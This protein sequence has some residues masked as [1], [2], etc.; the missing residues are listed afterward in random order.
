MSTRSERSSISFLSM[1]ERKSLLFTSFSASRSSENDFDPPR[2]PPPIIISADVESMFSCPPFCA[3][4]LNLFG[5]LRSSL[6]HSCTCWCVIGLLPSG[7][8]MN[9]HLLISLIV[10]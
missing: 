2:D 5:F 4:I 1:T 7:A 6:R 8:F 3:M 10:Y 9:W